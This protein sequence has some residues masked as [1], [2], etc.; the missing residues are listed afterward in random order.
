MK[1]RGDACGCIARFLNEYPRT[2]VADLNGLKYED[3]SCYVECSNGVIRAY[4][5]EIVGSSRYKIGECVM[6]IW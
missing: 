2:P 3:N 5:Y 4:A 1:N 6:T